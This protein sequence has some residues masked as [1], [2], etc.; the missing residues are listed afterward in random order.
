MTRPDCKKPLPR[1]FYLQNPIEAARQSV[2]RRLPTGEMLSGI[3]VETEAYRAVGD[4]AMGRYRTPGVRNA[5]LF[6]PPGH[7]FL[8]TIYRV[9]TMF[10]LVCGPE[11]TAEAVL[12]RALE[13]V[14]GMDAMRCL[15][16]GV[17]NARQLTNGPG[18]LSAALGLTPAQNGRDVTDPDGE[19]QVVG[20]DPPPFETVTTMRIGLRLGGDLPYR[21]YIR[22]NPYVSRLAPRDAERR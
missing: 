16:G 5:I 10:N 17:G 14:E 6:G 2:V 15:R 19:L 18:K 9:Q 20:H 3:I 1:E 22:G 7:A 21:F 13:P 11:G 8:Y 12:I 4:P